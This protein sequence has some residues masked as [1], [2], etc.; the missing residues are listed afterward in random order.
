MPGTGITWAS[1]HGQMCLEPME[2]SGPFRTRAHAM[3]RTA[4][5]SAC[6]VQG[7]VAGV[8]YT[9]VVYQ[10]GY[11]PGTYPVYNTITGLRPGHTQFSTVSRVLMAGGQSVYLIVVSPHGHVPVN[12]MFYKRWFQ[13]GYR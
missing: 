11:I 5:A 13:H 2:P 1:P 9:R 6:G 3:Y 4:G 10:G 12:Y 7:G 8:V